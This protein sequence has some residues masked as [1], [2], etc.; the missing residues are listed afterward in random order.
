MRLILQPLLR[1]QYQKHYLQMQQQFCLFS[2][3]DHTI[4]QVIICWLLSMENHV[5]S[6]VFQYGI[7]NGQSGTGAGFL[8]VFSFPLSVIL[9]LPHTYVTAPKVYR[10]S[11]RQHIITSVLSQGLIFDLT[12]RKSKRDQFLLL[13]TGEQR[14]TAFPSFR[15]LLASLSY[16]SHFKLFNKPFLL[17]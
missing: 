16:H 2:A 10:R 8:S 15:F 13:K 1:H 12:L 6:Q 9:P 11:Y 17:F 7:C 4:V 3:G 5:Q 14:S